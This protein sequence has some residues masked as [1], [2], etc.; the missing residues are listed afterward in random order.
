M[1]GPNAILT[2]AFDAG[3]AI[4]EKLLLKMGA[5][6][7]ELIQAVDSAAPIVAVARETVVSGARVDVDMVGIATVKLG[8]TVTRGDPL[9]SDANAKAVAAAPAAGVNNYIA[10]FAMASG[11]LDDEIE[12]LQSP[13]RIQG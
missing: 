5:L 11:V 4:T 9:T 1:A 3:G 10:G 2:K 8:G 13:G 12:M 6:D 7:E